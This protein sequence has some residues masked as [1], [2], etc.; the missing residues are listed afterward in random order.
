MG[1]LICHLR[2]YS[3][4]AMHVS[5]L[6]KLLWTLLSQTSHYKSWKVTGVLPWSG[7]CFTVGYALREYGA[8]H[9]DDVNIFIASI[10]FIYC[11]P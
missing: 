2:M 3:C 8:F 5:Y 6:S 9:Y 10:V 1:G 11:A 7:L 4:L